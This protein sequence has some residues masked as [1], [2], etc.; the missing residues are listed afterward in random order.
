[1]ARRSKSSAKGQSAQE[2]AVIGLGRFGAI[3]I[4]LLLLKRRGRDSLVKYPEEL[5]LVG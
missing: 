3:T 1:M 4:M 2:F 5:V